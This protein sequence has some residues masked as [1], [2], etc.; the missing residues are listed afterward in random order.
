MHDSGVVDIQWNTTHSPSA[1]YAAF[2][3]IEDDRLENASAMQILREPATDLLRAVQSYPTDMRPFL[4]NIVFLAG[5]YISN[6]ELASAAIR[7]VLPA[8]API[9]AGV[10]PYSYA[11]AN[12]FQQHNCDAL[13]RGI[14]AI[15]TEFPKA[16]PDWQTGVEEFQH[17]LEDEWNQRGRSLMSRVSELVDPATIPEAAEV[18]LVAPVRGG[19]DLVD[20]YTNIVLLEAAA[21]ESFGSVG[22]AGRLAWLLLTLNLDRESDLPRALIDRIGRLSML[23]VV[24]E[25]A[26]DGECTRELIETA[27]R[28]WNVIPDHVSAVSPVL[29]QWWQAV[30]RSRPRWSIALTGLV[31]LLGQAV[32]SDVFNPDPPRASLS[33]V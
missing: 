17:R 1:L 25:A 13:I 33:A 30:R 8:Y 4:R 9:A 21:D 16:F 31:T 14:T 26:E 6:R 22:M 10:S 19:G 15:E 20:P 2:V 28:E 3:L 11:P 7:K 24:L 23:P 12:S 18:M 32:G 29:L 27:M 5:R